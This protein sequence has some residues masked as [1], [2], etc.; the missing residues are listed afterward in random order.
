MLSRDRSQARA[1]ISRVR[2]R[3]RRDF[4]MALGA[5]RD[6]MCPLGARRNLTG[7]PGA[8]GDSGPRSAR[9]AT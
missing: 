5:R 2:L 9:A 4:M 7:V 3:A 1:A 8:Q 6:L